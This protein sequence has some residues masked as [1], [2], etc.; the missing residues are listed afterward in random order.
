V[1]MPNQVSIWL[2]QDEPTGVKWKCTCGLRAS[3]AVTSGVVCVA[4]VLRLR[5]VG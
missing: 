1:M 2:I 4:S 5:Y 3:H